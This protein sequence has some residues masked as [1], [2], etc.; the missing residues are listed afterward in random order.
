MRKYEFYTE[1]Q[2]YFEYDGDT[3]IQRIRKQYGKTVRRDWIVF[4]TVKEAM[5]YFDTR[6]GEFIGYYL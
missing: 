4:S 6:C 2:D 5:D 3:E 1:F